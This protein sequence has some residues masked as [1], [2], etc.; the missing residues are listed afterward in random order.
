MDNTKKIILVV[1]GSLMACLLLAGTA[2]AAGYADDVCAEAGEIVNRNPFMGSVNRECCPGLVEK[3]V[4]KSHSICERPVRGA[5]IRLGAKEVP[6][7][8]VLRNDIELIDVIIIFYSK[9]AYDK[10]K[11]ILASIYC[12]EYEGKKIRDLKIIN[13]VAAT[14]PKKLIDGGFLNSPEIWKIVP[15]APVTLPKPPT[16]YSTK[17]PTRYHVYPK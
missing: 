2:N 17:Y 5:T 15:D 7:T 13:G 1:L 6:E 3:R 10:R 16:K 12:L 4:S 8:M 11:I 9:E 14:V